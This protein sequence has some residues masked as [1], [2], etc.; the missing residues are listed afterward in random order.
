VLV[1]GRALKVGPNLLQKTGDEV[2][3]NVDARVI[4]EEFSHV[5]VVLD[6]VEPHPGERGAL[7]EYIVGL[8][9]VPEEGEVKRHVN[10]LRK[11]VPDL[12]FLAP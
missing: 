10:R 12:W 3:G 9:H 7:A 4:A 1:A 6:G 11:S 5:E 8:V 2:E